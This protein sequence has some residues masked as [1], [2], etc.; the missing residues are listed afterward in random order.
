MKLNIKEIAVFGMLGSLIFASK[1]VMEV[2]PNVHLIGVFIVAITVVYRA[3]ALY[4][5]Y[6]FVIILG[7]YNGFS[8]WWIPYL[9]IWTL[10]WAI[11]MLLPKNMSPKIA[12][13]VYMSVCALHGF[14][15]G[16][17]YAPAQALMFGYDLEKTIAWIITGLSWDAIHGVS[18]FV[19]GIL[20]MPLIKAIQVAQK[21]TN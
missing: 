4:P 19:C 20:I 18:N 13:V 8:V 14:L 15:Y 17:L 5:I 21:H 10:L 16:I 3:K 9:Y 7:V 12:S 2:L 1:I 11:V 6:I